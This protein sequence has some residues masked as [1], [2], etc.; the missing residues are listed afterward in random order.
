MEVASMEGWFRACM[1]QRSSFLEKRFSMVPSSWRMS[2]S[3][4]RTCS[5]MSHVP[6]SNPYNPPTPYN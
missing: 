4:G 1:G 3:H 2:P 6:T 5:M